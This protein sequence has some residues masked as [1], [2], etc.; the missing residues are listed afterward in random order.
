MVLL[1]CLV[2]DKRMAD[3]VVRASGVDVTTKPK[4]DRA[5]EKCFLK[6]A[7]PESQNITQIAKVFRAGTRHLRQAEM[8]R[9]LSQQLLVVTKQLEELKKARMLEG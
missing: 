8:L 1:C 6:K 5:P 2:S 9:M 7:K 3:T 4:D